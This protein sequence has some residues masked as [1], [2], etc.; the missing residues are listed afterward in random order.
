MCIDV[1]KNYMHASLGH[2][3]QLVG[4][5]WTRPV[6]VFECQLMEC[7]WWKEGIFGS[8]LEAFLEGGR[9]RR[10]E[11]KGKGKSPLV[12]WSLVSHHRQTGFW[13]RGNLKFKRLQRSFSPLC[14]LF[15]FLG[16][17]CGVIIYDINNAW[18]INE[19]GLGEIAKGKHRSHTAWI[20]AATRWGRVFGRAE[21]GEESGSEGTLI[22]MSGRSGWRVVGR[23]ISMYCSG[24]L[25]ACRRWMGCRGW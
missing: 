3:V 9:R 4:R 21:E 23:P 5:G 18:R 11:G 24:W 6:C 7:N 15:F 13:F 14:L 1:I 22:C 8:K 20:K 16:Y 12:A 25:M 17:T 10:K 2:A 19:W